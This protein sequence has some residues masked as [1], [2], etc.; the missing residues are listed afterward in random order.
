MIHTAVQLTYDAVCYP[1]YFESTLCGI[2]LQEGWGEALGKIPSFVYLEI[3]ECQLEGHLPTSW[4][5]SFPYLGILKIVDSQ[6]ANFTIPAGAHHEASGI[7]VTARALWLLPGISLG[8]AI[9]QVAPHSCAHM[10]VLDMRAYHE[11]SACAFALPHTAWSDT[12]KITG[13]CMLLW[14]EKSLQLVCRVGAA[15]SMAVAD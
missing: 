15:R 3:H 13:P 9:V 5:H 10:P 2:N 7:R 11:T 14:A 6:G 12:I 1:G 4:A 8:N